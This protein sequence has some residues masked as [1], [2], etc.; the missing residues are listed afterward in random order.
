MISLQSVPQFA[1]DFIFAHVCS[2][3]ERFFKGLNVNVGI[4][5]SIVFGVMVFIVKVQ[6]FVGRLI[7]FRKSIFYTDEY[8]IYASAARKNCQER[9]SLSSCHKSPQPFLYARSRP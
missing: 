7:F 4:P 1:F 3:K 5:V 9:I 2:H 6:E 8:F